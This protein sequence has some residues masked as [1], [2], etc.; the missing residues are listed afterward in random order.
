MLKFKAIICDDEKDKYD[1]LVEML[2]DEMFE[3][4]YITNVDDLTIRLKNDNFDVLFLDLYYK[5]EKIIE[6]QTHKIIE[7]DELISIRKAITKKK[8]L[9]I[10]T[11]HTSDMISLLRKAALGGII[12]EWIDEQDLYD[13]SSKKDE[14]II[15]IN[16]I[17]GTHNR[18][19]S[20]LSM[21][22]FS[23]IHYGKQYE[24]VGE[25]ICNFLIEQIR[26][27]IELI[28]SKETK[29][30]I[31]LPQIITISGDFT[32]TSSINQLERAKKFLI[33]IEEMIEESGVSAPII[34]ICPGN[35]DF[36]WDDS[37]ADE[38]CVTT[39]DDVNKTVDVVERDEGSDDY[40]KKL[41]W[42]RFNQYFGDIIEKY[43]TRQNY[44]YWIYYD[45]ADRLG[46]RIF[47]INTAINMTYKNE[48]VKINR[49]TIEDLYEIIKKEKPCTGVLLCHHP[50]KQWG[51]D[52]F[53]EEIKHLLYSKLNIRLILSGHSHSNT[54][55]SHRVA[56]K[57]IHEIRTGSLSVNEKEMEVFHLPTF[58][59]LKFAKENGE[60]WQKVSSFIFEYGDSKYKP[61]SDERGEYDETIEII[62]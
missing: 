40:I 27:Q 45:Y 16:K 28:R 29:L 36:N 35:H 51:D 33:D 47:S 57:Y 17:I 41:K 25:E 61:R 31:D 1:R 4:E 38:K 39:E 30:D 34:S 24:Y 3:Y 62:K 50:L 15:R 8:K 10:Y 23:D 32:H 9:I 58:R 5:L 59:I 22:H 54:I 2:G 6:N 13:D 12:D 11:K 37:I 42:F 56:K 43:S 53:V 14:A 7:Y 46:L 21:Y 26:D 20:S 49:S 52:K 44:P 48:Q 18:E 55:E 60:T 19:Q